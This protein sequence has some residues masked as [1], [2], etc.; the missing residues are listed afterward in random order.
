M[1]DTRFDR[2]IEARPL[3][4]GHY[5]INISDAWNVSIGPNGGYIAAILLRGLKREL[6]GVQTRSI[7]F[8]FLSAAQP[9]PAT[10]VVH[11]LKQGRS[12]STGTV[13]L[14]QGER[15]IAIA[16]ATFG[17]ARG[18]ADAAQ[19]APVFHDLQ[20]PVV[21]PPDAIEQSAFMDPGKIGHVPFRDHY[22]QRLAIGPIPPGTTDVARVGGWTRF[23]EPRIFDDEAVVAISDAW[24]PSI[25][26]KGFDLAIHAP[27]VDHTVHFLRSLPLETARPDD[28]LLVEFETPVAQEGF[29]IENGRLWSSDGQLIAKSRQLAVLIPR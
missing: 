8:H 26:V 17:E 15:T 2:D 4:N 21:P 29:L 12:L 1:D 11:R 3:G 18:T 24:F 13:T 5:S 19:A 28:F 27:T 16:L 23:R 22:D 7:T 14:S 9:G 25:L 10:Y 6:G 20:M